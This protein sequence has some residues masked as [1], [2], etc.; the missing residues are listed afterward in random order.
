[1]FKNEN[2]M[3]RKKYENLAYDQHLV[4]KFSENSRIRRPYEE[5]YA[6]IGKL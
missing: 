6:K 1:M 5:C 2:D 3:I 4:E